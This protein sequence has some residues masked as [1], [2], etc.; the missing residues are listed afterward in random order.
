M[1]IFSNDARSPPS[2][3]PAP[4]ITMFAPPMTAPQNENTLS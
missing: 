1:T 3:Q 4:C 2:I